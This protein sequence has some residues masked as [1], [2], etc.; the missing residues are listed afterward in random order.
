[1]FAHESLIRVFCETKRLYETT[2]PIATTTTSTSSTSRISTT[3]P[4]GLTVWLSL[5]R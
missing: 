2:A 3:L 1:M 4:F 5:P